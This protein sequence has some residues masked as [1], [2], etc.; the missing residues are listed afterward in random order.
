LCFNPLP[1]NIYFKIHEDVIRFGEAAT[2]LE[3]N[4]IVVCSV[5]LVDIARE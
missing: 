3:T 4:L 1:Q 5:L 2:K